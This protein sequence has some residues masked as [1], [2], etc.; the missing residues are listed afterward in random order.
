MEISYSYLKK[1]QQEK[2]I[3]IGKKHI[4]SSN[5]NIYFKGKVWVKDNEIKTNY[6]SI[7]PPK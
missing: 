5:I 1:I 3:F 2:N 6:L 4:Q 7:L